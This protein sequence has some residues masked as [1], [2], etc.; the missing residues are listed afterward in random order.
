[1]LM[2][3]QARQRNCVVSYALSRRMG[4]RDRSYRRSLVLELTGLLV[5]SY[6]LGV[7]LALAAAL[8]IAG[9]VDPLDTIPPDPLFVLPLAGI[10]LALVALM[11]V[12][13]A[14]GWFTNRR[15]RQ[16]NFA[17]VMRLAD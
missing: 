1:M 10:P 15:A 13:L 6:L 3:L 12:A 7:V 5:V 14:G 11:V 17:E 2:Y 9:K 8:V 16:T 4:L